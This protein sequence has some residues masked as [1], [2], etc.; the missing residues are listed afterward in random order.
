MG[1]I[2]NH[3]DLEVY[4]MAMDL[5]GRV[6][7]AT[8]KFPREEMF[9]LTDQI[10]RSSRAISALIAEGWRRRRY[11]AAFVDKLN[12]AEAEAA[13]TQSWLEHAVQCGYLA[14]EDGRELH[15][16]CHQI[17]GKLVIMSNS[18]QKWV[19]KRTRDTENT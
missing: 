7:R 11:A 1:R 12:Q 2:Q 8:Q 16:L 6:F 9:A 10:R 4:Q 5:S 3:W 18:P 15:R 17:I 19:L 14:A 13:E